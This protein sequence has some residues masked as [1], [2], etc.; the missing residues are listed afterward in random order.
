MEFMPLR[1]MRP[2]VPGTPPNPAGPGGPVAP[3]LPELLNIFNILGTATTL[4]NYFF[5][6]LGIDLNVLRCGRELRDLSG[7]ELP[8]APES[9]EAP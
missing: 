9:L 1:P 7:L 4:L 5:I 8:A 2:L 3:F 6:F